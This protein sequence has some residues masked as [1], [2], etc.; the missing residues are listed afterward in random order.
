[1]PRDGRGD[2]QDTPRELLDQVEGR[3]VERRRLADYYFME[4]PGRSIWCFS[5]L[6]EGYNKQQNVE[7]CGA[8]RE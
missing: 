2:E 1:M 6:L 3:E 5:L 8:E 4:K 7:G